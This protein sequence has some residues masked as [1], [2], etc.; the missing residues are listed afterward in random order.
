MSRDYLNSRPISGLP[1]LGW[2]IGTKRR[3]TPSRAT[4][5]GLHRDEPNGDIPET[6]DGFPRNRPLVLRTRPQPIER[7]PKVS[8]EALWRVLPGP[9]ETGG[10]A[11]SGPLARLQRGVVYGRRLPSTR[12]GSVRSMPPVR[13]AARTTGSVSRMPAARRPRSQRH[14]G[15]TEGIPMRGSSG[16]QRDQKPRSGRP[17]TSGH[18]R[19]ILAFVDAHMSNLDGPSSVEGNR[20]C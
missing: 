17:S 15:A 4:I 14:S 18:R 5:G 10:G 8:E 2:P 6:N 1:E 20:E 9:P 7:A 3:E 19:D 11:A 12:G 16:D 13:S